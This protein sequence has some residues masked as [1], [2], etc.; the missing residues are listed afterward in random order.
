MRLSALLTTSLAIGGLC[1]GLGCD[2]KPKGD[3]TSA[4]SVASTAKSAA[5]GS[6]AGA[7]STKKLNVLNLAKGTKVGKDLINLGK[8]V[9]GIGAGLKSKGP[10]LTEAQFETLLLGL[11]DCEVKDSGIDRKCEAYKAYRE[12]RKNRGTLVKDWGGM[13]SGMGRKHI[14]NTAPAVRIQAAN[15][16]GSIFG[17][18]KESQAA[19]ITAAKSEAHPRVLKAMLRSISSSIAKNDDVRKLMLDKASHPDQKVRMEVVGSLTSSWARG[20]EGTL[21][22]AM[23]MV[24]KDAAP[25]VRQ[26]ACRRLGERADARALPLLKTLTASATDEKLYSACVRGV[27]AMW[28]SPVPHK[29]PSEDAFKHTL[30][31]FKKTPRS[32]SH[33]P[34]TSISAVAWASKKRFQDAAP[35]YKNAELVAVLMDVVKD[36]QA[37]WLARTGG[38]DALK[39]LGATPAQF[40]E[41][42]KSYADAAG[43]PSTDKHVLDKIMKVTAAAA[44]KTPAK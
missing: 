23:E 2:A 3:A 11:K 29:A 33:P 36:R 42:A 7:A 40:G 9:K 4:K 32:K 44:A 18:S 15:L 16:M 10:G 13:L 14:K 34:W 25:E 28:S 1:V 38:V 37:N 20:T 26:Y 41:L 17:S 22:K 6:V 5:T 21:E 8:D 43:K 39:R 31:L 35:W 27:I 12:G 19:I 30:A 24:E